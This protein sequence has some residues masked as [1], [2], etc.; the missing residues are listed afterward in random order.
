M[1]EFIVN[2]ISEAIMLMTYKR[3]VFHRYYI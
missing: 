1:F 3:I 2:F